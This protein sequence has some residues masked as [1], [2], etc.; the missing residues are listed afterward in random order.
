MNKKRTLTPAELANVMLQEM[1]LE[2]RIS[3]RVMEKVADPKYTWRL[4]ELRAELAAI[5]HLQTCA[6]AN[7][8]EL[9][10]KAGT[11]I[12]HLVASLE[13]AASSS[14]RTP[15]FDPGDA[16][17]NPAAATK[18]NKAAGLVALMAATMAGCASLPP[19]DPN[20]CMRAGR[21]GNV[22]TLSITHCELLRIEGGDERKAGE[23]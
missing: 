4:S 23:P 20:V 5:D 7:I 2:R 17:S 19:P 6:G 1:A 11:T 14:G 15:G 8:A 21:I 3:I 12:P 13:S 9:V 22:R 18:P 16:G 10:A